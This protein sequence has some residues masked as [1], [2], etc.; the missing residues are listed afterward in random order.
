MKPSAI[1]FSSFPFLRR[2]ARF[3]GCYGLC[4]AGLDDPP[5]RLV[6]LKKENQR[7]NPRQSKFAPAEGVIP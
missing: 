3:K 1:T 7:I 5:A 2:K 6:G 4:G